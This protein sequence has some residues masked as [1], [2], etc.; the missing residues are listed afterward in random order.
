M[1]ILPAALFVSVVMA[2]TALVVPPSF[3]QAFPGTVDVTE[4]PPVTAPV[5][6]PQT[7]AGSPTRAG[8]PVRE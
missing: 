2:A 7:P 8:A 3:G 4:T 5:A 6:P 1:K